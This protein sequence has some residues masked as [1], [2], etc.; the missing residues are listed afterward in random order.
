MDKIWI[1]FSA[2]EQVDSPFVQR[3]YNYFG[4]I[5]RAFCATQK[6][7]S[8]VEGLSVKKAE[9]LKNIKIFNYENKNEEISAIKE[10]KIYHEKKKLFNG[11][12]N[13]KGENIIDISE[14][15]N[16]INLIN[17]KRGNSASYC[18]NKTNI[19]N[20]N[21]IT[22]KKNNNVRSYSTFRHN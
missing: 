3:L 19:Y 4:D 2:I 15:N 8:Q 16:K 9:N 17:K 13:I 18:N 7:L 5:E 1:A 20:I 21:Y 22:Y 12:L 6:E 11:I 10:I 14:N